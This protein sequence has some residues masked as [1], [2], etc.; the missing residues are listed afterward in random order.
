[1]KERAVAAMDFLDYQDLA[2]RSAMPFA[3]KIEQIKYGLLALAGEVG[4]V[5]EP[6][7]KGLYHG[8]DMP[9]KELIE[10]ELGDC[11]WSLACLA[12]AYDTDLQIIAIKNIAKLQERY[13]EGFSADRS[14]NRVENIPDCEE[15]A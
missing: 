13:P 3:S 10:K 6:L 2:L 11:L 9:S 14:I 15:A 8:H 7:K 4:E 12:D 1:M 5:T